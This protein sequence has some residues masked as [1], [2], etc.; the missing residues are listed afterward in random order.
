MKE[1]RSNPFEVAAACGPAASA[2]VDRMGYTL[3]ADNGY[4]EALEK[5]MN[6]TV[7]DAIRKKMSKRC[8]RLL[9]HSKWDEN[10]GQY[11]I[12]FTLQRGKR[13]LATSAGV[14][15]QGKPLEEAA[16]EEG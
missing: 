1:Q 9:V 16:N 8:E 6:N 2:E 13:V 12:W 5:N 11:V 4:P 14:R 3:L 7:R 15:L 10:L